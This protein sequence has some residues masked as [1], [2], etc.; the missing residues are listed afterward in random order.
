MPGMRLVNLLLAALLAGSATPAAAQQPSTPETPPASTAED[1]PAAETQ[2][3]LPVSVDRIREELAKTPAVPLIRGL[4]EQ[5]TFR[6]GVEERITLEHFFKPEDFQVG[7]VP[8][9]GLYAY[10]MQR[11]VSNPV[12]D[13]LAQPYAAFSGGQLLTI[14]IENLLFKYLGGRLTRAFADDTAAQAAAEAEVARAIAEYC[15]AQPGGGVRIEICR[16][17]TTPR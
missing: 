12:S 13:P 5:P 1:N 15:A 8:P 7:P 10:E 2:T 9:G 11:V 16:N 4:N 3:S 17:R 14:A 6:S